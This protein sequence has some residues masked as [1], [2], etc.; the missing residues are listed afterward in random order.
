M[1]NRLLKQAF[2]ESYTLHLQGKTSLVHVFIRNMTCTGYL[3]QGSAHIMPLH[4]Y[5]T[6]QTIT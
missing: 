6:S 2:I 1:E 4:F 5:T 3:F